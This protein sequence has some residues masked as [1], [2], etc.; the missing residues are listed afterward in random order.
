M[1]GSGTFEAVNG[2]RVCAGKQ[3]VWVVSVCKDSSQT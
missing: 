3:Q 1:E 2:A